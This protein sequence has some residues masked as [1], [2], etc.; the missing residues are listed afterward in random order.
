MN[1]FLRRSLPLVILTVCAMMISGGRKDDADNKR[2]PDTQNKAEL[3][4]AADSLVLEMDGIDSLSVLDVLQKSHAVRHMTSLKGAYVTRI[5]DIPNREGY[6]WVY[7]VN[8]EMGAVACDKYL[9]KKGDKIR[10][11]YRMTGDMQ[12]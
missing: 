11:H 6:F 5:D 8:G 12:L 10:W 2:V 3:A 9:T 4:D 7:S 1:L